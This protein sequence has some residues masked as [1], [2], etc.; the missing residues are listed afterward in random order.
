MA[1]AIGRGEGHRRAERPAVHA[2]GLQPDPPAQDRWRDHH[3]GQPQPRRPGRGFRRQ[4]QHAQRRTGARR[5]SPTASSPPAGDHPVP[6]RREPGRRPVATLP[7]RRL[8]GMQIEVVDPVADYAALMERLFDFDKI[9]ALIAGGLPDPLRRD[10]RGH[11]ALCHGAS[12]KDRLGASGGSVVNAEPQPD[13]GGGHPDPN[14][15]WAKR[16][17][18]RDDGGGRARFRRRLRRRR[19]PQHDRRP[20]RSTSRRPTA[21]RFWPPTRIWRR[22]MR[23]G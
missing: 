15:I 14:P 19:R 22:A 5:R 23:T 8:R 16:A 13:F 12:S 7:S 6:H 3:V 18:G 11:R 1:A 20:R 9:R 2:G 21:S 17:D 10:A 4:V